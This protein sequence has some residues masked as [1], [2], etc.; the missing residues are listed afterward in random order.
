VARFDS[1]RLTVNRP[2]A[3]LPQ[4]RSRKNTSMREAKNAVIR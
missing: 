4:L 2:T 3:W 1:V